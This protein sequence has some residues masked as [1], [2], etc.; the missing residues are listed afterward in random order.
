VVAG[1]GVVAAGTAGAA[2]AAVHVVMA[3]LIA[4]T[5]PHRE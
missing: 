5:G 4:R 2:L 3:L 1:S